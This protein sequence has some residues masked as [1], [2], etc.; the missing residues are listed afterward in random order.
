MINWSKWAAICLMIGFVVAL[1]T[2][3]TLAQDAKIV[4][5]TLLG[6]DP[7]AK[8][9]TMKAGEKE[10]QFSYTEQ[11]E[12]VGPQKD[13]QAV[14]VRQGSKLR[15]HYIENEKS[16]VATKIEVTEL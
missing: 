2:G 14:A 6:V 9:L 1:S 3:M 7:G 15:V 8:V 13:G 4:E 16:N 12:L 10:M 11:T 5:G